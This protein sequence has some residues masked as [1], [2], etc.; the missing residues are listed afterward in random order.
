MANICTNLL[1]IYGSLEDRICLFQSVTRRDLDSDDDDEDKLDFTLLH[2][3]PIELIENADSFISDEECAIFIKRYNAKD[4]R[5]WCISNWGCKWAPNEITWSHDYADYRL[6]TPWSPPINLFA[7][8][9]ES[10]PDCTFMLKFAEEGN[11]LVGEAILHNGVTETKLYDEGT[12]AYHKILSTF[13]VSTDYD[14]D[15]Y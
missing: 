9:S 6:H 15:D 13:E 8:L 10:F 5:S 4:V 3:I 14:V 7:K 11:E 2:P 12:Y 1:H